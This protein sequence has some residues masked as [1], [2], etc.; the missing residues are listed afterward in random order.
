MRV[1]LTRLRLVRHR[2]ERGGAAVLV[3]ISMTVVVGFLAFVTD[4]GHA[5]ANKRGLQNGADSAALAVA[6]EIA[7]HGDP[8]ATCAQ[9][10]ATWTSDATKSARL[11]S[12]A[13]SYFAGNHVGS[14]ASQSGPQ[15]SCIAGGNLLQVTVDT[16]QSSPAFFGASMGQGDIALNQRAR[17]VVAPAGAVIGLRPFA[18]CLGLATQIID[19][20]TVNH[21]LRLDNTDF[22]CGGA[23]G[24]WGMIDF[25]GGSN[26]TGE[27]VDWILNGYNGP[28]SVTPPAYLP[29]DPGAPSPGGL[30]SAMNTLL[31]DE[32]TIPVYDSLT[33]SGNNATFHVMGFLSIKVCGWKFNNKQGRSTACFST[34]MVGTPVPQNYLQVRYTGFIPIGDAANSCLIGNT[35]CDL[36]TRVAKLYD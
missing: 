10:V 29:G 17:A 8:S 34:S 18:I 12:L 14:G 27:S 30:E 13:S 35:A 2:D 33:G 16:T 28:V 9:L 6:R 11:A 7:L 15:L 21:M 20:P 32:I 31:D 25:N 1:P 24:N 36:G 22:G 3:A 4:F 5:Y 19:A 23:S 26:P